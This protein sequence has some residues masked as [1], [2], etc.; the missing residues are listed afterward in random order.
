MRSRQPVWSIRI[1]EKKPYRSKS[2]QRGSLVLRNGKWEFWRNPET[3]KRM[4]TQGKMEVGVRD[5]R[6][7]S[8]SRERG[9]WIGVRR[10][11]EGTKTP[12]S[13]TICR[14]RPCFIAPVDERGH[15]EASGH[16]R[17][18]ELGAGGQVSEVRWP[19]EV[20]VTSLMS[21]PI[22]LGHHTLV[23]MPSCLSG[24]WFAFT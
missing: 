9:C 4:V 16:C 5:V 17:K 2:Q 3:E 22:L 10:L 23:N 8:C 19:Q 7:G 15:C 14:F 12:T 20:T 24:L 6:E 18:G 13:Y 1:E 21:Q 11:Q